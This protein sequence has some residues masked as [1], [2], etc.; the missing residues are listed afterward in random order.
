MDRRISAA[1]TRYIVRLSAKD[2]VGVAG[3]YVRIGKA[4]PRRYHAALKLSK[5]K[6]KELRFGSIDR[7][8]NWGARAPSARPALADSLRHQPCEGVISPVS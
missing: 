8:G 7:F 1:R 4:A 3:I 6:L 5:A 2:P